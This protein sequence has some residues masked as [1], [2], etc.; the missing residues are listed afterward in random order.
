MQIKEIYKKIN[1]EDANDIVRIQSDYFSYI[2]VVGVIS[3][4]HSGYKT[5]GKYFSVLKIGGLMI[6]SLNDY[7]LNVIRYENEI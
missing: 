7:A 4:T 2:A 6:F 3:P 5:I 1:F